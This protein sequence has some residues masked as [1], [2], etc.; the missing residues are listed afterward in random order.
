[1]DS[2]IMDGSAG[3]ACE[4][5]QNGR[6]ES[7]IVIRPATENDAER[8]LEIYAPYITDTAITFE[9]DV[10]SVAE[11]RE[12]IRNTLEK[13]PYLC[14]EKDG[15]VLGYAYAG[16]F[17][18]RAAYQYSVEHSIYV[19]RNCKGRG[20]GRKLYEVLEEKLKAQGIRN[21]YACIA[22]PTEKEDEYLD[23]SSEH[24]HGHMGFKKVGKFTDC[25]KKFE[26]WYSMIWMEKRI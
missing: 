13:Y 14:A 3:V 17:K 25:A 23:F 1:M 12:R 20:L 5:S 15:V 7:G 9:Y 24:F 2:K 16:V 19:D 6:I 22:V 10:P 21:L 26:R 4:V 8:L 18:A 11:F